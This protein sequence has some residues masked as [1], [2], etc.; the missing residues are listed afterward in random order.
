MQGFSNLCPLAATST[1]TCQLV[2]CRER[3]W[4]GPHD[5]WWPPCKLSWPRAE[6]V[7]RWYGKFSSPCKPLPAAWPCAHV[8]WWGPTRLLFLP[9]QCKVN[10]ERTARNVL[11]GNLTISQA[12]FVFGQGFDWPHDEVAVGFSCLAMGGCC[13]VEH[14]AHTWVFWSSMGQQGS[15]SFLFSMA[16]FHVG[17]FR[18]ASLWMTP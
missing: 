8:F 1:A 12:K 11:Q 16:Q 2:C 14:S 15:T 7:V 17:S 6:E 3:C 4:S 10:A 13:A 9:F 18:L 5:A